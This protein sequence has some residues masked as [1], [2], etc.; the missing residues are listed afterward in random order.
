M[1]GYHTQA[2]PFPG[3]NP[4]TYLTGGWLGPRASLDVLWEKNLLTLPEYE[5]Q[6]IQPLV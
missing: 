6:I 4:G 1:S 2:D 5:T 3:K